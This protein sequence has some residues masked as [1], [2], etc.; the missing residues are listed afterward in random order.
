[1]AEIN[2]Y[3]QDLDKVVQQLNVPQEGNILITGATGLIGSCLVDLLMR[4]SFCHIY[5]M[6]RNSQRA[7]QRF[8]DYWQQPRFH[9]IRHDIC[10]S[11]ECTE[12]FHYIIHAASNASPNF[13]QQSPVE[14]MKS[15]LD[16]L[17]HLV[18]Y[19]LRHQMK[20]MVYI[21]SGEVY[22]EGDGSVFSEKSSG[23]ID[24]LSPRACY[25]SSKRA[26]ETLCASYC[27][28]Y[29]AQIVIAR[30]CHTYGPYFTESDNRVYAQFIRNILNDEDIV[31]KSRGEQF[32]S[33]L[34]V[35]DCAVAMLLLL[36][37][38]NSGEAYNVANE[39][40]NIT[41]RQL[42]EEIAKIGN[43]KVVFDLAENGNT[44]PIT[45]AVFSTEK[46]N[47]LGWKPLFSI[48]EGLAHTI[49]SMRL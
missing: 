2:P 26:A 45:K 42:A 16:G 20:R 25:P 39:E 24:I 43:K 23:Y 48:E 47:Q 1:M 21:S 33:W 18:E 35:V 14:V 22:G 10:Q 34:Y 13:F 29:G 40:S 31:M 15:N 6:G 46:L 5:A 11:L 41:I 49:Q 7:E 4:H 12:N 37:K 30:P 19:G 38:G 9:F 3:R 8:A 27:Q 36:T 32:R 44:T 17:C 28:E